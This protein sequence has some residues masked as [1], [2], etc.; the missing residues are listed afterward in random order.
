MFSKVNKFILL[1]L[2]EQNSFKF[3]SVISI[4]K[5]NLFDNL[6]HN[7]R[8]VLK[9][10]FLN[11]MQKYQSKSE[12]FDI[13]FKY[14]ENKQENIMLQELVDEALSIVIKSKLIINIFEYQINLE[15]ILKW[16]Q[17]SS[18]KRNQKNKILIELR[19]IN[20]SAFKEF[21][22]QPFY[23]ELENQKIKDLLSQYS[24]FDSTL[25]IL[26]DISS[27][28]LSCYNYDENAQFLHLHE[29]FTLVKFDSNSLRVST[30]SSDAKSLNIRRANQILEIYCLIVS[31]VYIPFL[32]RR[33][34]FDYTLH[35]LK[36]FDND[37]NDL[38]LEAIHAYLNKRHFIFI[39]T[40]LP[41]IESKLRELLRDS[42]EADIQINDKGGYDFKVIGA[43]FRS[44]YVENFLTR[45]QL[46]ILSLILDDRAGLNLRN[47]LAHGLMKPHEFN[48]YYSDI[49]ILILIFISCLDFKN[50][51]KDD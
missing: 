9:N 47:K 3:E 26:I 36:I 20:N 38:V 43:F 1:N 13:V 46:F 34:D 28:M 50:Y 16:L 42:G 51:D 31:H 6:E 22:G 49:L 27:S 12:Y 35:N 39:S 37:L 29:T 48:S 14:F 15:N 41:L 10:F 11:N 24:V 30:L 21:K 45:S 32:K 7:Q 23:F 4:I 8:N 18:N 44:A 2:L 33:T 25:D 40:I 5:L 17:Y 19:E